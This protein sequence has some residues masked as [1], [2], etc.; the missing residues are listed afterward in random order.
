M[1]YLSHLKSFTFRHAVSVGMAVFVAVVINAYVSFSREC[2]ILVVA[3]L[4]SQT[5]RGTPFKQG[6]VFFLIIIFALL[7]AAILLVNIKQHWLLDSIL[8]FA[9]VVSGYVTF[10]MRP[11]PNKL[12]F[13]ALFFPLVLLL[14]TLAPYESSYL[15]RDCII[16]AVIGAVIGILCTQCV[17]PI[18]YDKEFRQA[19]IPI[20]QVLD[21]YSRAL[22]AYFEHGK[23]EEN[24]CWEKKLDMERVLQIQQGLYPEWVYEVGFNPGLRAGFR[25]FLIN[26]E[27]ITDIF[28]SMHY[29]VSRHAEHIFLPK[30]DQGLQALR[31]AMAHCMQKNEE[32]LVIL[33]G[34]FK[35]NQLKDIQSDFTSDMT[36]LENMLRLVVPVTLEL[37][38]ISPDYVTLTA[39]VRDIK[40]MRKLLLQL[41]MSLPV[42]K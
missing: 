22:K 14:A 20:L 42:A 15:M 13:F 17:L 26:L 36:E 6:I 18:R 3:F 35:D 9:M 7:C 31:H 34:Y 27:R 12:Y 2:W 38:D 37:L 24:R 1:A 21:D 4:V 25:F 8:G 28:F 19:L 5:T 16:D 23:D 33:M 30:E 29:L 39:L 41:V 10:S 32:L 11:L 40:D